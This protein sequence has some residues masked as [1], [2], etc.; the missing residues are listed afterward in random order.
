MFGEASALEALRLSLPGAGISLLMAAAG[1]GRADICRRLLAPLLPRARAE[2]VMEQRDR[3]GMSALAHAVALGRAAAVDELLRIAS[4]GGARDIA[5]PPGCREGAAP[6]IAALL[7]AFAADPARYA[8]RPPFLAL[9]GSG[10]PAPPMAMA[11]ATAVPGGA[12]G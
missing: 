7:S 3:A 6:E 9:G 10:A 12:G 2:T 1:A 4:E 8:A 11:M 5:L